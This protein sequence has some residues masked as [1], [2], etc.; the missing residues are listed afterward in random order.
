[1][2]KKIEVELFIAINED[3]DWVVNSDESEVLGQLAEDCGGYQAKVVK[4]KLS[5]AP[6]VMEEV[7]AD[8]PESAG[9]TSELTVS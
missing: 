2:T 5:I 3:G 6:P 7:Q 8:V 4:V 9:T 1:M